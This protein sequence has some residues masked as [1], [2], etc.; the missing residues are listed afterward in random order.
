[1]EKGAH[2]EMRGEYHREVLPGAFSSD[3]RCC[4]ASARVG[5]RILIRVP[6]H[7]IFRKNGT[8]REIFLKKPA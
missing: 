2:F 7:H 5:Y 6:G 3:V 1:L 8:G 4:P